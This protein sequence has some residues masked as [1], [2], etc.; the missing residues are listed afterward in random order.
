MTT[1]CNSIQFDIPDLFEPHV[2]GAIVRSAYI[3]P[4]IQIQR[5][6]LSIKA[7]APDLDSGF[8]LAE[9]KSQFFYLLYREKI[10]QETIDI[11]A[12]LYKAAE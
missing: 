10:Y 4:D 2:D 6:N 5:T 7:S 9:F 1:E 8:P 11:R 3:Y 12:S